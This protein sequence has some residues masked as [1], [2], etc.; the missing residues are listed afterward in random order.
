M[1]IEINNLTHI[2]K[3][4][5]EQ[6][7]FNEINGTIDQG[8]K[9]GIIGPSGMGK[10]TLVNILSGLL[11]PTL[12]GVFYDDTDIT[13]QDDD[14]KSKFRRENLGMVFQDNHLIEELDVSQNIRLPMEL[15]KMP[16]DMQLIRVDELLILKFDII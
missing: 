16:R 8:E 11:D 15:I 2:Y 12:G 9:I 10:T 1:K 7:I 6:M 3:S 5:V 4:N 13:K 14:T